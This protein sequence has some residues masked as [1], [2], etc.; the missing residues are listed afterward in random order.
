MLGAKGGDDINVFSQEYKKKWSHVMKTDKQQCE[1]FEDI[2]A[3][4]EEL[5]ISR[6]SKKLSKKYAEAQKHRDQ[7]GQRIR[8]CGKI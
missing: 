7:Y 2:N 8:L 6:A 5:K 1:H 3:V 4:L